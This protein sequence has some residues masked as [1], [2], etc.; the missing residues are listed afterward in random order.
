ML[1]K[2]P[3]ES[4]RL[5]PTW[6]VQNKPCPSWPLWTFIT[7]IFKILFN[8]KAY[9]NWRGPP[10]NVTSHS[11]GLPTTMTVEQSIWTISQYAS[12]S[13]KEMPLND[14]EQNVLVL[15]WV[16]KIP[17]YHHECFVFSLPCSWIVHDWT[18]KVIC[19][20]SIIYSYSSYACTIIGF[21]V[22]K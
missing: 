6:M 12:I 13:Q 5:P 22:L 16:C 20:Y 9:K 21:E 14:F 11:C 15:I 19:P 1:H 18:V 3:I 4:R 17:A 10:K 2:L 7:D 8:W